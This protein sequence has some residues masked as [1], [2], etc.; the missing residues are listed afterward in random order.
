MDAETVAARIG[1]GLT[2]FNILREKGLFGFLERGVVL[3][4]AGTEVFGLK[5]AEPVFIRFPLLGGAGGYVDLALQKWLGDP[6]VAV[7]TN[8][9]WDPKE[10]Q[11]QAS[12]LGYKWRRWVFYTAGQV[13]LDCG[14]V[15]LDPYRGR[16]G[17]LYVVP[18]RE[19]K[20]EWG[21]PPEKRI[22]NE[23]RYEAYLAAGATNGA[24]L[25][26][27]LSTASLE[28]VDL[29]SVGNPPGGTY[30]CVPKIAQK[31]DLWCVP[32][33]LD[34]IIEFFLPPKKG[35]VGKYQGKLASNL[36]L[37]GGAAL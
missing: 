9:R 28:G 16:K 33:V 21:L 31:D 20:K 34:M 19:V 3:A 29:C 35:G 22:D 8:V 6:V 26:V 14:D 7:V 4:D 10:Y 27:P 25:I 1:L 5:D 37:Y 17:Q 24:G 13:A 12:A 2:T 30:H 32:A 15:F 36:G 11:D 23:R 18:P